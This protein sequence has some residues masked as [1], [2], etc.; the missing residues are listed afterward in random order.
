ML[1]TDDDVPHYPGIK[2][3]FIDKLEFVEAEDEDHIPVYRV[4]NR[5][6]EITDKQNEPMV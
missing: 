2:S 4:M 3:K 5:N 1:D 6:G